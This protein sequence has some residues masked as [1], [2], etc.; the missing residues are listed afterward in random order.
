MINELIKAILIKLENGLQGIKQVRS[1]RKEQ[2]LELTLF[3]GFPL[4]IG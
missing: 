3:R 2:A 1:P 4:K